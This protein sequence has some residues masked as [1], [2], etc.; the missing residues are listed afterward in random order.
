MFPCLT[1]R[2]EMAGPQRL[3]VLYGNVETTTCGFSLDWPG[4]ILGVFP[5]LLLF[6]IR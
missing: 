4:A 2:L 5:W 6:F 1:Y 3:H